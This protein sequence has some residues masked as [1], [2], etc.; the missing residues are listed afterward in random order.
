MGF[1]EHTRYN[2]QRA[3]RE[4]ELGA[5]L[6]RSLLTP[7]RELRVELTLARDNGELGTFVGYRVQHDGSRGPMK[8]GIRFSPL[9]EPGEVTALA[10]L[11]TWK[12]AVVGLPY[13]GAKG[14]IDCDPREL[15]RA[16]LQRLTRTFVE[17]LND[18]IGPYKDVPAPDM[19]TNAQTMA[20]IVDEYA[21]FHGWAPGVVTGK[22]IALGGSVGRESATGR[23]VRIAAE[24]ALAAA[25]ESLA[26]QTV[27]IQGFGNVGS[28]AARELAEAGAHIVAV[29]DVS[30][31][32][33]NREGLDVARLVEHVA[34][35]GDVSG[36]DGGE[37]FPGNELLVEPC[38]I[39][40]PAAL[41]DQITQDNAHRLACR[42]IVE[43][44]NGPTTP[45][46]DEVLES[47]DVVVVPD[48][49]AN[50]GGV[51]VSYF[52]WVQNL[53]QLSWEASRVRQEL[54]SVLDR[55]WRSLLAESR[56]AGSSLRSAAYRLAIRRVAEATA[57][58]S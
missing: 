17:E 12:T 19:G 51:T 27:A 21:K 42:Y 36:F 31:A 18:F 8:G 49:F 48:I 7:R 29:S 54:T 13:G 45:E 41:E 3:A 10:T 43:G 24:H 16:E 23:G 11:M 52:E 6:E 22:P 30:G 37:A 25:S 56:S 47:R 26:G 40:V 35:T 20:W 44:A 50:A 5:R 34:D 14:G 1:L 33:R 28:W 39:L 57:L 38:D 53:Q 46:A 32:V 9:V 58:R 2:F 55:A 4:L 15:S